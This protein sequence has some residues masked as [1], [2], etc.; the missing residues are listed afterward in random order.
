MSTALSMESNRA[1]DG[2][3][4][5]GT[6][7]I[8]K[9]CKSSRSTNLCWLRFIFITIPN[10]F[11]PNRRSWLFPRC[12]K[13]AGITWNRV[14]WIAKWRTAQLRG[15]DYDQLSGHPVVV[16]NDLTLRPCKEA[17]VI[18]RRSAGIWKRRRRSNRNYWSRFLARFGI[19]N[20][21]NIRNWNWN[22]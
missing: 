22:W 5:P 2:P 9:R 10:P 3:S 21:T 19:R 1:W 11:I 4:S 8:L 12:E 17:L 6:C 14:R 20:A 16:P 13:K 15:T 7:W 18:H